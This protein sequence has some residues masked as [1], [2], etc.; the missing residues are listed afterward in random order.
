MMMS[1]PDLKVWHPPRIRRVKGF[2]FHKSKL[3]NVSNAVGCGYDVCAC[4][5]MVFVLVPFDVNATTA[6]EVAPPY[7]SMDE[8]SEVFSCCGMWSWCS[9]EPFS[10]LETSRSTTIETAPCA[11]RFSCSHSRLC[12]PWATLW[13]CWEASENALSSLC[14]CQRDPPKTYST[15]GFQHGAAATHTVISFG[16]RVLRLHK[17]SF[18]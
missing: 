8:R 11:R 14:K 3:V 15:V 4:C 12:M 18:S 16:L 13:I 1:M 5:V 7:P 9:L 17:D 10:S 6:A 2:F